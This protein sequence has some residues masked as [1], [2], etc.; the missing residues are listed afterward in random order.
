[1]R[2]PLR[3]ISDVYWLWCVKCI[4]LLERGYNVLTKEAG[5]VDDEQVLSPGQREA[6]RRWGTEASGAAFDRKKKPYLTERAREFLAQQS[7]CVIA[8]LDTQGQ[9]GGLL[10]LEGFGFVQ[11]PDEQT[12]LLRLS[13]QYET[14]RPLERL[15]SFFPGIYPDLALF[16]ISHAT[17]ERLCVQGTAELLFLDLSPFSQMIG[18]CTSIWLL[19][20]VRQAFFHCP[21]Y[22][23]TNVAGLT[24]NDLPVPSH[25]WRRE[26]ILNCE[27]GAV[28]NAVRAFLA[29]QALCYVCTVNRQ[30]HCAVNHRGGVPGF[31]ATM[32]PHPDAPG[33]MVFLPDYAGNGAFEAIGNILE[34]GKAAL[35]IP[36][37][38]AQIALCLSGSARVCERWEV[39]ADVAQRCKGAERIIAISVQR[40]EVQ[41]GDWSA[42]QA[43]ERE[44]AA[45]TRLCLC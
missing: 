32:P 10:A 44:R 41:S 45:A 22:I 34:T 11:T 39:S 4:L 12:C 2:L 19:L 38:T 18:T 20:R 23:K 27:R 13:K 14:M 28:S 31:L 35:L 3:N 43:Y 21:R 42:S 33:G 6:R 36:D 8:G 26:D 30:G 5:F 7:F 17:R 9:P 40:I 1:M 16:F 25:L 37:F 24:T 15:R 29:A